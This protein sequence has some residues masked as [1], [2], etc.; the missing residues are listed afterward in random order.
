MNRS[1][2]ILAASILTLGVS[3]HP[4][5]AQSDDESATPLADQDLS[6]AAQSITNGEDPISSEK[7]DVS[8]GDWDVRTKI[9][10]ELSVA[11]SDLPLTIAIDPD[12]ASEVCPVRESDLDQ[13]ETVSAVRTCAA[14]SVN[15]DLIAA[16]KSDLESPSA[17][18][19]EMGTAGM[20]DGSSDES[21]SGDQG[22]SSEANDSSAEA[23]SSDADSDTDTDTVPEN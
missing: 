6:E 4:A 11:I 5:L 15:E 16:V 10:E 14:K 21:G 2:L 23:S 8:L 19:S 22:G 12:L 17:S 18:G 3:W 20:E 7:V 13:Q 1:R 9:S